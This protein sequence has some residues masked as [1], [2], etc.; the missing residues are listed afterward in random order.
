MRLLIRHVFLLAG[1]LAINCVS[2]AQNYG[3]GTLRILPTASE[4]ASLPSPEANYAVDGINCSYNYS[5][6]AASVSV[7]LFDLSTNNLS[8]NV[9]ITTKTGAV[10]VEKDL[11]GVGLNW[12]IDT[13]G[14]ISRSIVGLPDE[15]VPFKLIENDN[16]SNTTPP[17]TNLVEYVNKEA[18]CNRDIYTYKVGRWSGQFII[19]GNNI[20]LMPANDVIIEK[21]AN[22]NFKI[23]DPD[24]TMYIFDIKEELSYQYTPVELVPGEPCPNYD[25]A[26]CLWRLGKIVNLNKND[27]ITFNYTNLPNKIK[28]RQDRTMSVTAINMGNNTLNNNH[29]TSEQSQAISY[30]IYS[31]RHAI[32]SINS[33]DG[34]IEFEVNPNTQ[35]YTLIKRKDINNQTIQTV[36]F[37]YDSL[38]VYTTPTSFSTVPFLIGYQ[39]VSDS[40]RLSGAKFSYYNQGISIGCKDIFGHNHYEQGMN[41]NSSILTW[42]RQCDIFP[43]SSS[44]SFIIAPSIERYPS[45]EKLITAALKSINTDYGLNT[46]FEYESTIIENAWSIMGHSYDLVPSIRISSETKVDAN[47]QRIVKRL[48]EY[49]SP[50]PTINFSNISPSVFIKT[51]GNR[52][53]NQMITGERISSGAIMTPSSRMP[54]LDIQN[55]EVYHNTVKETTLQTIFKQEV[56]PDVDV[57]G[58]DNDYQYSLVG[59]CTY[60]FDISE[61]CTPITQIGKV[62]LSSLERNNSRYCGAGFDIY[63]SIPDYANA[64][65]FALQPNII[66]GYFRET[67]G[68]KAPLIKHTIYGT[69]TLGNLTLKR[70]VQ[71]HYLKDKKESIATGYYCEPIVRSITSPMT[72]LTMPDYKYSSDFNHFTVYADT[73]RLLC[74]TIKITEYDSNGTC[75]IVTK[76]QKFCGQDLPLI[77]FPGVIITPILKSLSP[78]EV[79]A[80]TGQVTASLIKQCSI[81]CND[82]II[83]TEYRYAQ[84]YSQSTNTNSFENLLYRYRS[85]GLR[86]LL[87]SI[88]QTFG[89]STVLRYYNYQEQINEDGHSIILPYEIL[90]YNGSD[91]TDTIIDKIEY[92]GFDR[93]NN[94]ISIKRNNGAVVKYEWSD[95]YNGLY[96]TSRN[97]DEYLPTNYSYIPQIG[98]CSSQTPAGTETT[99]EYKAMRLSNIK[100][101]NSTIK[102]FRYNSYYNDEINATTEYNLMGGSIYADVERYDGYGNPIIK[103]T[104]YTNDINSNTLSSLSGIYGSLLIRDGISRLIREY[105]QVPIASIANSINDLCMQCTNSIDTVPYSCLMYDIGS[106]DSNPISKTIAG[107]L[108]SNNP[109]KYE[110]LFNLNPQNLNLGIN[111]AEEL[112]CRKYTVEAGNN[113]FILCGG[114]WNQGSLS[115]ISQIDGDGNKILIFF[116]LFGNKI[117]ERRISDDGYNDT[118]FIYDEF[119]LITYILPP[120]VSKQLS[121][122]AKGSYINV[123]NTRTVY[124]DS[125]IYKYNDKLQLCEKKLPG[126]EIERFWYDCTG[127]KIFWQDGNHR[128]REVIAFS[129][130]DRFG[131]ITLVGE[132]LFNQDLIDSI[133]CIRVLSSADENLGLLLNGYSI[134]IPMTGVVVEKVNYYDNYNFV[135]DLFNSGSE[136]QFSL[137]NSVISE[138]PINKRN[139]NRG[140]QTGTLRRILRYNDYSGSLIADSIDYMAK[141]KIY[142]ERERLIAS[143]TNDHAGGYILEQTSF[144]NVNKPTQRHLHRVP[145]QG[146]SCM[147][148]IKIT[149][150]GQLLETISYDSYG[151][152]AMLESIATD[153][154][155]ETNSTAILREQF[156]YNQ[157]GRISTIKF[158]DSNKIPLI[159]QYSYLSNGFLSTIDTNTGFSQRIYYADSPVGVLPIFNGNISSIDWSNVNNHQNRYSFIYDKLNRLSNA[160]YSLI[161]STQTSEELFNYSCEYS[162]DE[163]HRPI[164]ILRNGLKNANN[165]IWG[166]IDELYID[167]DNSKLKRVTDLADEINYIGAKDFNDGADINIEYDYDANG[168]LIYDA[169]KNIASIIWNS[170]N[171]PALIEFE[172]DSYIEFIYNADGELVFRL[173]YESPNITNSYTASSNQIHFFGPI[174]CEGN[175]LSRINTTYGYAYFTEQRSIPNYYVSDYQGNIRQVVNYDDMK[176]QQESNYYPFGMIMNGLTELNNNSGR[177]GVI[178]YGAALI[179]VPNEYRYSGK[180]YLDFHNLNLNQFP[181]RLHDPTLNQWVSTDPLSE[182]YPHLTPYSFCASNPIKYVDPDGRVI[183]IPP[184]VSAEDVLKI[185][186]NMQSLTNDK[187]VYKTMSNGYRRIRIAHLGKGDKIAGTNL[188]RKLNSSSKIVY[189]DYENSLKKFKDNT[190]NMATYKS[191]IDAS[192]SVGTDALIT[193]SMDS[194]PRLYT[195]DSKSKTITK[196]TRPSY[197]GLGHELIHASH[198]LDGDFIPLTQKEQ[199]PILKNLICTEELVTIGL[200]EGYGNITENELR[201]ENKVPQRVEY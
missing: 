124:N 128:N 89:E 120:S 195:I 111:K 12:D 181:A 190:H 152:I 95:E 13:G 47:T 107:E 8:L 97:I 174:R 60:E 158:G 145:L 109:T 9:S 2:Y 167:Y 171:L 55:V 15:K 132:A 100:V 102:K 37:E 106:F 59:T 112:Y 71:Y 172:D 85:L 29:P 54:G 1:I 98:C 113:G 50:I 45:F 170:L 110:Y 191:R 92:L 163:N 133:R 36:E 94:P 20:V 177:A 178:S 39:I 114:Y 18:D 19:E 21:Y 157:N 57:M 165:P 135:A 176:L 140:L 156:E 64:H 38:R 189:I 88:K 63:T 186:G 5:T 141:I 168:N 74:D 49:S 182:K 126:R 138:L 35:Q 67:I 142:D 22:G 148:Q 62:G 149:A 31:N 90:T 40:I 65:G 155:K 185:V 175:S 116:D 150:S 33:R 196:S 117:L 143:I 136:C 121:D 127:Q 44:T 103:A 104:A 6:G 180:G 66:P 125:Y 153:P 68:E 78:D 183:M 129:I 144:N 46:I 43:N 154:D 48:F 184:S 16:Y 7:P 72:G 76:S 34:S 14:F 105:S 193:F 86:S 11:S 101:E 58:D 23:I 82:Y 139:N 80:T 87:V 91:T 73:Y 192:N 108:F 93:Y 137:L 3:D 115:T 25:N 42:M 131:R 28:S 151:R 70:Q 179:D 187:L 162:Y 24:G 83:N 198:M 146:L 17:L 27:S 4:M 161:S 200:K 99:Y 30:Y 56:F 159:I 160:N 81:S 118:Y 84:D 52:S 166:I 51:G 10:S 53:N 130:S 41:H 77:P 32:H 134:N 26:V 147:P 164:R 188:I 119:G 197:I 201:K 173:Q 61:L 199:S 75:K 79:I 123:L 96:P 69:D 169:N 194:D 122:Y